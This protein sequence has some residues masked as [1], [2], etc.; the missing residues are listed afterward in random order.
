MLAAAR[1][2]PRGLQVV[3]TRYWP[4][5]YYCI[6]ILLPFCGPPPLFVGSTEDLAA[7]ALKEIEA[8]QAD[9]DAFFFSLTQVDPMDL[10]ERIKLKDE[11]PQ[12]RPQRRPWDLVLI[13]AVIFV[14]IIIAGLAVNLHR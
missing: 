9:T 5:P 8:E 3:L 12:P 13:C 10:K 7:Y 6:D 11:P 1:T 14:L 2:F 4:G